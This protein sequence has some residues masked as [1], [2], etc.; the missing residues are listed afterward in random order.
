MVNPKIEGMFY[1]D[2]LLEGPLFSA[3]DENIIHDFVKQARSAGFKFNVSINAGRFSLLTVTQPIKVESGVESADVQVAKCLNGL[4]SNYSP[5]ECMQLMSTLRSVEYVP[6]R[7]IQTIY[8]IKPNGTIV[9]EQRTI[10]AYTI[11]PARGLGWQYKLKLA[12]ILVIA[13]FLVISASAFFLPYHEMARSLLDKA[14][15]VE[16]QQIEIDADLYK[17]F[18]QVER[19]EF[20]SD[21][22]VIRILCIPLEAYPSTEVEFNELWKSSVESLSQRLV[23]E[24]LMR[25][26]VRCELFDHNGNFR[27]Q[28]FCYLR[29]TEPDKKNFFVIAIAFDKCLDKI[30]IGY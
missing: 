20:D 5:E 8:G 16:I 21:K 6:G 19:L 14:G 18:F 28:Q 30:K 7:E 25:N 2:G 29:W 17:N 9:S 27:G 15:P 4:L 12:I 10:S 22:G 3:D 26:C 11:T 13:L 1:L 23:V 24:A